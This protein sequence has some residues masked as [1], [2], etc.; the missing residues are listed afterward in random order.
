M[1]T[2]NLELNIRARADTRD[3]E[4]LSRELGKL[5]GDLRHADSAFSSSGDGAKTLA[6]SMERLS[7]EEMKYAQQAGRT[8]AALE[9]AQRAS[10]QTA[11]ANERL[12]QSQSNTAAV[13][14]RT[15]TAE[16]KLAQERE[17]SLQSVLKTEKAELDTAKAREQLR[18]ATVRAEQA[19]KKALETK[20]SYGLATDI[21]HKQIKAFVSGA[22][23]MQ[24]GRMMMQFGKDAISAASDVEEGAAKFEQ[25][26]RDLSGG[27]E[28]D[29]EAMAAANR[30][31]IYD[32]KD[33]ASELQN[34][35]VP[36]GFAREEAAEFAKT[37]TQLGIDI[38]AF[39][40]KA[41]PDVIHNLTSAIVGNHEAVRSYG[42][43]ITQTVINQELAA[44][45]MDHLTGA[46]LETAK[47]QARLN[48]I[49]RASADAQGAAVREADSYA[50]V[51]KAWDAAVLDLQASIGQKLLPT[52]VT[53][54]ET[55][56]RAVEVLEAGASFQAFNE[57]A[58]AA[59]ETLEDVVKSIQRSKKELEDLEFWEWVKLNST[60][61]VGL[62][63]AETQ[64]QRI[65]EL[66]GDVGE[67]QKTIIANF[68]RMEITNF[69]NQLGIERDS[70]W[71]LDAVAADIYA[72][73]EALRA[74]A[75]VEN[76]AAEMAA[77]YARRQREAMEA[78][79]QIDFGMMAW[80]D[81]L[82]PKIKNLGAALE[83]ATGPL[84]KYALGAKAAAEAQKALN[85]AFGEAFNDAPIDA[86][87]QAQRDL[88]ISSGEWTDTTIDNSGRIA[89]IQAQLAADLTTEQKSQ[90]QKQLKD[91]HEFSDEYLSIVAQLEGDLTDSK[92]LDLT[93][94]LAALQARH[95]AATSVY[96]G[97]VEAAEEAKAAIIAANAAIAESHY[98]RA[99]DSL[100]AGLIESGQFEH[101]ADL[102]VS[103][104]IMTR[105]EAELRQ[106]YAETAA[107]LD[108][109]V[110]S[111]EFYNLSAGSQ[112]EV[113]K[114]I[115]SGF[116]DTA[117]AALAAAT[118]A[119]QA[120]DNWTT[121][122]N[123]GPDSSQIGDYYRQLAGG[124]TTAPDA[125]I[126]TAVSVAID[127]N[128]L[129][130]F[131]G[132]RSDLEAFDE[133]VYETL[134]QSDA[135]DSIDDFET[136]RDQLTDLTRSPWI[137]QLKYETQGAPPPG[138]PI[139]QGADPVRSAGGGK[140]SPMVDVTVNN[141]AGVGVE[142]A[143][144]TGVLSALRSLG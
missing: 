12:V 109:L 11:V 75:V 74:K 28:D 31:S 102:A 143:V 107:V 14:A 130:E 32:L 34:T 62:D 3:L 127:P 6:S 60:S 4:K 80:A 30:R 76:E 58:L 138:S 54:V 114:G 97:D 125:G 37:I 21:V 93:S 24:A 48:I 77:A 69:A 8:V 112:G 129:R 139:P 27:V 101:L 119:Q 7:T 108:G 40:N 25:V 19:E 115:A 113:I 2:K 88:K 68:S 121:F 56:I 92:R 95:G 132:F 123:T 10:I 39:S 131:T 90:L 47:A 41:D 57:D 89:S 87:I 16:E 94:E 53:L 18:V 33:F 26:F 83:E 100:A 99:Y 82:G 96:S 128:S 67:F 59:A 20:K 122:F 73:I 1:T 43:V 61:W 133:A 5:V 120:H 15:A 65:A 110:A 111:T 79:G 118:N 42:I 134:I 85:V 135:Q 144:R 64:M 52:M 142:G 140:G 63:L 116:W 86:L 29:L 17:K 124:G 137:I 50:N 78:A 23:L 98:Q 105:E 81:E 44:M 106:A 117:E 66:S 70:W 104:G 13:A 55:A 49:M 71:D 103:L 141:Y 36:L 126:T 72:Y 9:A 45:G 51:L 22:A 136:M 91:L 35:F 84:D 46:A 38:A